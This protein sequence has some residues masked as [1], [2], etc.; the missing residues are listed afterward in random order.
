[1]H[2]AAEMCRMLAASR[3]MTGV[4]GKSRSS[5]SAA[6]ASTSDCQRGGSVPVTSNVVHENT[7]GQTGT[8]ARVAVM[9]ALPRTVS[10]S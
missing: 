9:V 10:A 8:V 3:E 4:R 7:P 5:D 2:P 1:M 6:T